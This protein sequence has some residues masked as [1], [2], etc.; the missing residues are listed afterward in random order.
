MDITFINKKNGSP[1][2]LATFLFVNVPFHVKMEPFIDCSYG[3]ARRFQSCLQVPLFEPP[4][5]WDQNVVN[6]VFFSPP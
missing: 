4:A 2:A 1:M 3:V 5:F 6:Y